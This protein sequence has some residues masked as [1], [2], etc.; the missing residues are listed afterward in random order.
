[1]TG[2]LLVVGARAK[3]LRWRAVAANVAFAALLVAVSWFYPRASALLPLVL[4]V[5]FA[6]SGADDSAWTKA[7]E[8]IRFETPYR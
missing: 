1:M 5:R 2:M 3:T 8:T 6:I 7:R 4:A